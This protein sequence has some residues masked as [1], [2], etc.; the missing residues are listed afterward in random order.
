MRTL[1]RARQAQ[2]KPPKIRCCHE[3]QSILVCCV[4][5][6]LLITVR[7]ILLGWVAL[8]VITYLIERTLLFLAAHFLGLPWIPTVQLAL[9]CSGLV[10][11]GWIMGRWNRFD[12]LLF[13]AT[14]AIWNG[15]LV[16]ID[17]PW[18]FRLLINSFE[19]S[20]YLESFFTSLVTHVFL[21][22]SL[23][24]GAS[25]ARSREPVVLRIK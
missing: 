23:F 8:F 24:I 15:G 13:A 10:A 25:L 3:T 21:F 9:T 16:P 17:I 2:R 20:R 7:S 5:R 1:L 12:V 14:L 6:H 22:G 4:A 11:T 18:L 19:N